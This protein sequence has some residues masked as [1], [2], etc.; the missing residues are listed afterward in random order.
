[1]YRQL[2]TTLGVL[3]AALPFLGIPGSWKTP[4]YFL[5]GAA[6]AGVSY[7]SGVHK[8]RVALGKQIPVRRPRREY[9]A[10]P[11]STAPH[12]SLNSES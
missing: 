10:A 8:K 12:E 6:I 3:V 9:T 2:V 11:A 7:Y 4:L 5:L 1:M